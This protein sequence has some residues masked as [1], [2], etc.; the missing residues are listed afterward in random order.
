MVFPA[1]DARIVHVPA[2]RIV[3]VVP[4]TEQIV[5]V[6][7]ANAT[8]SVEDA[9]AETVNGTSP[10][11]FAPSAAKVMDWVACASTSVGVG[12]GIARL[13]LDVNKSEYVAGAAEIDKPLK[14]AIPLTAVTVVT[15]AIVAPVVAIVTCVAES[16]ATTLPP[17]S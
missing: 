15:P 1:C 4:L 17:A 11:V 6:C 3:T 10:N 16:V 14:G 8:A 13:G 2:E 7:E 9:V 5:P 12:L